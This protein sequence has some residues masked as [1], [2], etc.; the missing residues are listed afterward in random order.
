M[1]KTATEVPAVYTKSA[2]SSCQ[3]LATRLPTLLLLF[4]QRLSQAL[5]ETSQKKNEEK[6]FLSCTNTCF[7][8]AC[9]TQSQRHQ[10]LSMTQCL[11]QIERGMLSMINFQI[12]INFWLSVVNC[13]L[14][15]VHTP[16]HLYILDVHAHSLIYVL[17]FDV[18]PREVFLTKAQGIEILTQI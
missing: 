2:R 8:N 15:H 13:I 12:E 18:N 9:F 10:S 11:I 14:I 1:L 5:A 6:P 4:C 3:R 17:P 16:T 7:N